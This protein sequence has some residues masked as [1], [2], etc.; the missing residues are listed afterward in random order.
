[1]KRT[2]SG[3]FAGLILLC[4][5]GHKKT[6][7]GTITY[8]VEYE[9]P[10]SLKQYA[11]YLP[12]QAIV[13]FKGDSTISIQEASEESTSVIT[14]ANTHFMRALLKSATK[15]YAVD[16]DKAAQAEEVATMPSYTFTKTADAKTIAGYHAA[17]YTLKDKATGENAEAWFTKDVSIIPNSLTTSMDTTLGVPLA[18]TIKQNGIIVKTTVKE[19][20]FDPVPAGVFLTPKGY[21]FLT[22]QQFR[23][24]TT[25]N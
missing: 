5:C 24:M 19:I 6:D 14:H 7:E 9:L 25:G 21:E 17:K 10:D 23:E 15:H 22:P 11:S 13:Y 18:F 12:K 4:A 2:I 20:K 3:L 8:S 1:M 16:Y